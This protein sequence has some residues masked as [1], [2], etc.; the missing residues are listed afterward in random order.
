MLLSGAGVPSMVIEIKVKNESTQQ[1][2]I[3]INQELTKIFAECDE[4]LSLRISA[5]DDY[6][7]VVSSRTVVAV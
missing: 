2:E 7:I 6:L 3:C 4:I 1:F 5:E